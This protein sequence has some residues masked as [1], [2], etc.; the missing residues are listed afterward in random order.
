MSADWL[1]IHPALHGLMLM[2]TLIVAVGPQNAYVLSHAV[3]RAHHLMI[4]ALCIAIDVVMVAM[5]VSGV[6]MLAAGAPWL[7]DALTIG[8]VAFLAIYGGRAL[9]A[10]L[11]PDTLDPS[12]GL[13]RTR[14]AAAAGAL[15]VS[16][17]NPH[18]YLDTLVLLGGVGAGYA[19]GERLLFG[20]GAIAGSIAWFMM[21]AVGGQALAPWLGRPCAWRVVNALVALTMWA[22]AASLAG[23]YF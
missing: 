2:A 8:G 9:V 6:G 23:R 10:A 4:A 13:A 1:H 16:L 20:A 14:R 11:H 18:L 21:L 19:G 17:L 5:G 7:A 3:G 12:S 15:A 22:I